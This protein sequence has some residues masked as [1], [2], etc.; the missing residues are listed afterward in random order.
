MIGRS[1]VS[2]FSINVDSDL[3]ADNDIHCFIQKVMSM[4]YINWIIALAILEK[5]MDMAF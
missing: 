2:C 3:L 4:K 1:D 5:G